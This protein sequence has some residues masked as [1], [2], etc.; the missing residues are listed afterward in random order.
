MKAKKGDKDV[1]RIMRRGGYVRGT[2]LKS[3]INGFNATLLMRGL[4]TAILVISVLAMFT[5]VASATDYYVRT[6]GLD[7]GTH[8]GLANTDARAWKTISYAIGRGEVGAGDTINVADGTYTITG[9]IMVTKE[10]TITGNTGNP[11]NVVVQYSNPADNW[12]IFDMRV[13]NVTIEGIK[14]VNGKAGFWADQSATGCK[15]SHCIVN[16]TR[17][18]GILISNGDTYTI[19]YTTITNPGQCGTLGYSNGVYIGADNTTIDHCTITSDKVQHMKWGVNL[20]AGSNQVVTE[21]TITGAWQA[22]IRV[23]SGVK[24]VTITNNDIDDATEGYAQECAISLAG[25]N[26]DSTVS[27]NHIDD[28]VASSAIAAYDAWNITIADNQIG[29]DDPSNDVRLEGIRVEGCGGSG[30]N[31]VE[32]TGNAINNTGYSAILLIS[33]SSNAY[34]YN[35]TITKC[36][37]YGEDGTGDWDYASIHVNNASSNVIVDN[38]TISDGINGIQVWGS[39]CSVTNNTIYD[40]GLTYNDTKGTGDGTYYNSGI[41]VGTNWLTNNLRPTGTTITGNNIYGNVYGL[42]V[43][44]STNNVSC[45]WVHDNTVGGFYL[46]GSTGNNISDN[47]IIMNGVHNLTTDGYQ[48][49][50]YNEQSDNVNAT[51]N[52]WG[53]NNETKINAS[54]YDHYD[55]PSYG[56]VN[57]SGSLSNPSQCAPIP[58]LATIILFSIGLLV[59]AGYVSLRRRK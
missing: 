31:R 54:I 19:E 53:T 42:Y 58:E 11:E 4:V 20:E 34:I 36:N 29:V 50:F 33:A 22:A 23:N 16:N 52:Y 43:R 48:W 2:R 30:A 40:M 57:F 46:N 28:V 49:D 10:V 12:L 56:I 6:G 38:N 27:G 44:A 47:N 7:D 14:T 41:I 55:N 45:N 15:I 13:S 9:R 35:N 18:S 25:H 51:K 24:P 17:E 39:S 5:A 26:N 21:T 32:V 37:N 3:G 1:N 8:D 59:L